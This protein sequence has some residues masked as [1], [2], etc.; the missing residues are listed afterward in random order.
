MK[1][2]EAEPL[3]PSTPNGRTMKLSTVW[4]CYVNLCS[5]LGMPKVPDTPKLA[6]NTGL[7]MRGIQEQ[8]NKALAILQ[9]EN[10][11]LKRQVNY[12]AGRSFAQRVQGVFRRPRYEDPAT[13]ENAV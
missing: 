6:I 13:P 7:R 1:K 9:R 8:Q 3:K 5:G 2:K 11:K 12:F 4:D 10:D